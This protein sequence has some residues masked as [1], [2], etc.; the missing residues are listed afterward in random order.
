MN[1]KSIGHNEQFDL[2]VHE[3]ESEQLKSYWKWFLEGVLLHK[4][5][6][7]LLFR[8]LGGFKLLDTI[9]IIETMAKFSSWKDVKCAAALVN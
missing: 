1:I 8:V 5:N 7:I 9:K 6:E 2:C 4:I 3:I